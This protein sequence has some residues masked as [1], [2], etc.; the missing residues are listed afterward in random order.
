MP[1][2]IH[3]PG[4]PAR[5]IEYVTTHYDVLPTLLQKHFLSKN[6]VSD[7][8]IGQNLLKN[9]GRRPYVLAGSYVG[10]GI[11]E[12]DRL[13]NLLSSGDIQMTDLNAKPLVDADPRLPVLE[14]ALHLM[15][16]YFRQ[17]KSILR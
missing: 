8:S 12:Q 4:E 14:D 13:T 3:W 17:P 1:L 7:Y 11:I 6:P 2:I 9:E 5:I 10:M 15:R 16:A